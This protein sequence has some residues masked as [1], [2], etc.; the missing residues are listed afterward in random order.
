MFDSHEN[1]MWMKN[2]RLYLEILLI[3]DAHWNVRINDG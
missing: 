1:F 2:D 3:S